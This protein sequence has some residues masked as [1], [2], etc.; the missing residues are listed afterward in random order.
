MVERYK[1]KIDEI[2]KVF[3][4]QETGEIKMEVLTEQKKLPSSPF[5]SRS[6]PPPAFHIP[7]TTCLR[8]FT[9][10]IIK[11][12]DAAAEVKNDLINSN[13]TSPL[14]AGN[15]TY[16]FSPDEVLYSTGKIILKDFSQREGAPTKKIDKQQ[17]QVVS[18]LISILE[19]EIQKLLKEGENIQEQQE[20][21]EQAMSSSNL[22]ASSDRSLTLIKYEAS[23]NRQFENTINQLLA[24]Q[25]QRLGKEQRLSSL[26]KIQKIKNEPKALPQETPFFSMPV[27]KK[28]KEMIENE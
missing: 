3:I 10:G 20:K 26:S 27:R 21:K 9:A 25:K 13:F 23:L 19:D 15:F 8:E 22:V 16:L 6:L 7:N 2:N 24:F 1:D 5:S 11:L 12:L 17:K 4:D 18:K 28:Q 14:A